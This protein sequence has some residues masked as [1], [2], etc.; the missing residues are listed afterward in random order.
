MNSLSWLIY[1]ANT[2]PS[3]AT[4]LG[5]TTCL[6]AIVAIVISGIRLGVMSQRDAYYTD[7]ERIFVQNTRFVPWLIPLFTFIS[8]STHLVPNKEAFYLIAAS[9]MGEQAT[10]TPE[11]GKLRTILNNV[12]DEQIE[13]TKPNP[14]KEH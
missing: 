8:I 9:E 10:L 6:S 5:I 11:F 7:G 2:L 12:L 4:A 14:S 1:L 13:N 3:L